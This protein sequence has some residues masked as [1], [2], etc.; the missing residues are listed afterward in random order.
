MIVILTELFVMLI[1]TTQLKVVVIET[2]CLETYC[3]A[4]LGLPVSD[5]LYRQSLSS[6]CSENQNAVGLIQWLASCLLLL[7]GHLAP[8]PIQSGDLGLGIREKLTWIQL[9]PS[10]VLHE[11][12]YI[13]GTGLFF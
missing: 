13:E 1:Q 7:D 9:T 3:K 8:I 11:S 12:G 6:L 10:H 5:R 4:F 2:H